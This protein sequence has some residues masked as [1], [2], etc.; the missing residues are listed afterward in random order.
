MNSLC[1]QYVDC[2]YHCRLGSTSRPI[3]LDNVRCSG[4]ESR[5]ASCSRSSYGVHNCDHSK[6]V[7]IY[8]YTPKSI[9]G[10]DINFR[11]PGIIMMQASI[12]DSIM[13]GWYVQQW[14][15]PVAVNAFQSMVL[16]GCTSIGNLMWIIMSCS[17]PLQIWALGNVC[18]QLYLMFTCTATLT[19]TPSS[20]QPY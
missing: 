11:I 3:W 10:S 5:L 8:C 9:T 20:F 18:S 17:K 13:H 2:T 6:D 1:I 14:T 7:A 19:V 16:L 15:S 12:I 4:T